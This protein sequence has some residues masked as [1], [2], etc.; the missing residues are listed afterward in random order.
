MADGASSELVAADAAPKKFALMLVE[1]HGLKEKVVPRGTESGAPIE[2][3]GKRGRAVDFLDTEDKYVVFT[4][5]GLLLDVAEDNLK[6]FE[7]PLP[8]EGGFDAAWPYY[9]DNFFDF[10]AS[11]NNQLASKSWCMI[12]MSKTDDSREEALAKA[13]R[14]DFEVPKAEL[15][16]DYLGRKGKGKV[17]HINPLDV[18]T[19][20]EVQ[21]L[22]APSSELEQ[23]D[24]DLSSLFAVM[25]PMSWDSMNFHSVGRTEGMV[26]IP[27]SSDREGS[28]LTPEPI[29]DDDIDEDD[30]IE[31]HIQFLRRRKLCCMYLIDNEGGTVT[32]HPREDLKMETVKLPVE[33]GRL[34]VFRCDQMSFSYQPLGKHL[35]LQSWFMTAAP[36][37]TLGDIVGSG[38]MQAELFKITK[39][40]AIPT[41]E[42]AHIMA[43]ACLTG[44]GVWGLEDASCMYLSGTDAHTYVPNTRFDTDLYFTKNGDT[45]LV[46]FAN[47]YHHHGGLVYDLEVMSFD[48]KFFGYEEHEASLMMPAHTKPLEVGYETLFRAGFT[49]KSVMNKPILVYLGDCGCEWWNYLMM[50]EIQGEKVQTYRQS[51]WEAARSLTISGQRLSYVLGLRGPAWVC[52]TACSSGLTAFCTAMYSMKRPTER[53][54]EAPGMDPHACGALAGGINMIVDAGVYIGGSGQH[55]LS[56]KGRCF[57]FDT[58]GDGYARGEGTSMAYVTLTNSDKDTELQEACAIGNKVNQD[59]RSASM[60]APNGPS[61]QLCI[62]ASLREAGVM[63]HDIT[64]SECH[65]TGTSLG[66][67]I[68]V[69]SLRGVQETDDRDG[70]MLNTSSKSNIGHLEANAGTTGL[71]KCVLMSKYGVGLPNCHMRSLNPHL[72]VSGWPTYMLNECCDYDAQSGMVGVSS[73]GVSGTNSHAEV[74]AMCKYGPNEAGR[75][76]MDI[77]DLHQITLTCPVTLGPIDHVTGE[78]GRADGQKYKA[79]ALREEL[80]DYD[81]CSTAYTGGFRFRREAL[82]DDDEP[83]NPDGVRVFIHGS[84]SGF[85]EYEEMQE[86]EDG[87]FT[88]TMILG[89][90]RC[91]SFCLVLNEIPDYGIYPAINH[92]TQKIYIEGVN[93]KGEGKKRWYIDGRNEEVPAGTAYQIKFRWGSKRKTMSWE[94]ISTSQA[95][96]AMRYEHRYQIQATWNSWRKDDL[97]SDPAE[98]GIWNYVAKIGVTGH[99]EFQLCRD[100]DEQQIIYPAEPNATKTSIPVRGPDDMS[101]GKKWVLT[102]PVGEIVKIRLE[103]DD[104]KIIVATSSK[105]MGEKVWESVE[106]WDR[107]EYYLAFMN[108]PCTK[109]TMD[110]EVPGIFR[111][112][113]EIGNNFN[114][115][116]RGLCEFFNVLVDADPNACFYPEVGCAS[117]GEC[118]VSGPDT[119]SDG[120]PFMIKSWQA[121]AG[122]EVTLNLL[123]EDRRQTV[124]WKWDTPPQFNFTGGVALMDA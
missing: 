118:I 53:G 8:Q 26:W 49:K 48:Y 27:F 32:L 47:S 17:S 104:G 18:L 84:W 9:Q 98:K 120:R 29:N 74:W 45:D 64:A 92:A 20:V 101:A 50:R 97:K 110:P 123:A 71:F 41:G 119:P 16:V 55:M 95:D 102:G 54:T 10:C 58:S 78:P 108:G 51:D 81:V 89:E 113:G 56:M 107:H 83:V 14:K 70:P 60:T 7:P 93:N 91:E 19:E 94:E 114:E 22:P 69:G 30:I 42:R 46:P 117:T 57:T 44:G 66:D 35:T 23:Y 77:Q 37:I 86:E 80:A 105:S 63:P 13:K 25:G 88:H 39:G 21:D 68:E 90:T 122:F 111:A 36:K 65:G 99:E 33:K 24:M 11:V 72:D 59:G 116:Y 103:V 75:K 6:E 87:T 34:L 82:E 109:M 43:G 76:K 1:V 3:N 2:V 15:V 31:K 73:F 121:G 112:R 67:P 85:S 28:A 100:H 12:Q 106:G 62:K 38:E 115:Q 61:Q 96:K 79:D 40:P 4:F 124:T 52:D 5:D